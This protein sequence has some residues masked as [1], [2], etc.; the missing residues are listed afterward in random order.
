MLVISKICFSNLRSDSYVKTREIRSFKMVCRCNGVRKSIYDWLA[1]ASQSHGWL[2]GW[3]SMD[4]AP[5]TESQATWRSV[6][7]AFG[8]ARQRR[9]HR[10][11]P[12]TR[13][14]LIDHGLEPLWHHFVDG[15]GRRTCATRLLLTPSYSWQRQIQHYCWMHARSCNPP[16]PPPSV[17]V[18]SLTPPPVA[19]SNICHDTARNP[20]IQILN[21]Y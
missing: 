11:R 20:S 17:R 5:P 15:G 3:P 16:P 8:G 19:G 7:L 14:S 1:K 9:L 4:V 21:K 2:D 6:H 10:D 13:L 12:T 18:S